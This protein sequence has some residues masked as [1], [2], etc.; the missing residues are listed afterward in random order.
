[1][2]RKIVISLLIL[3]IFIGCNESNKVVFPNQEYEDVEW[4]KLEKE[5]NIAI[6]HLFANEYSSSHLIRLRGAEVPHYHDRHNLIVSIISGK[7]I[8]HFKEHNV[9]LS[10]GDVIT[11]P[12]GVYHWAENVSGEA[13]VV[14]ATFAP[15]FK[16]KDKRLAE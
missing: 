1:M 8:L 14:F 13:S 12:K 5:R 16:G 2:K 6:K 9:L 15:A 10:K 3:T 7:S 4:S 11:I